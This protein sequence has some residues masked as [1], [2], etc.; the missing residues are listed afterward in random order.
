MSGYDSSADGNR[1]RV[2]ILRDSSKGEQEKDELGQFLASVAAVV[3]E[4]DTD[5]PEI[6]T[7]SRTGFFQPKNWHHSTSTKPLNPDLPNLKD[8]RLS[9]ALIADHQ[10]KFA[11]SGTSFDEVNFLVGDHPFEQKS[12]R[13][14]DYNPDH[15]GQSRSA[16]LSQLVKV[17][18]DHRQEYTAAL[19]LGR[20]QPADEGGVVAAGYVHALLAHDT[21]YNGLLDTVFKANPADQEGT[22]REGTPYGILGVRHDAHFELDDD[23]HHGRI[24]FEGTELTGYSEPS[25]WPLKFKAEMRSDTSTANSHSDNKHENNEWRPFYEATFFVPEIPPP[26]ITDGPGTPVYPPGDPGVPVPG[27]G[28]GVVIALPLMDAL[29]PNTPPTDDGFGY[30]GLAENADGNVQI[31]VARGGAT[32]W[33]DLCAQCCDG[34]GGG[35]T[36]FEWGGDGSDGG[37]TIVD[38]SSGTGMSAGTGPFFTQIRTILAS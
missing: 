35:T 25:G 31:Y 22:G 17:T 26:P 36:T 14:V 16:L 21:P 8:Q 33:V 20:S 28:T 3:L 10:H 12:T 18:D 23:I 6:V 1:D 19:V 30:L 34:C 38:G 29:A 32:D 27:D 4:T 7:E 24:R 15:L 5:H 2:L 9:V 37:T 13:I 11:W